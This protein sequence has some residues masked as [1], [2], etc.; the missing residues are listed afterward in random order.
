MYLEMK[1]RIILK[2]CLIEFDSKIILYCLG[3]T[4]ASTRH[5]THSSPTMQ[6]PKLPPRGP[7]PPPPSSNDNKSGVGQQQLPSSSSSTG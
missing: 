3:D 1:V 5:F 7:P 6:P 4:A 2:K